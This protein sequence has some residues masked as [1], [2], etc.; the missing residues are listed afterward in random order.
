MAM[1]KIMEMDL[2]A[3]IGAEPTASVSEVMFTSM[4]FVKV[5]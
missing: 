5:L 2:Y 4:F 3:L 1:D